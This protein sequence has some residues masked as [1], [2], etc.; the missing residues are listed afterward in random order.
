MSF[1][2]DFCHP[3][4]CSLPRNRARTAQPKPARLQQLELRVGRNFIRRAGCVS[5]APPPFTP[6]TLIRSNLSGCLVGAFA[7]YSAHAGGCRRLG[8]RK[9]CVWT[10]CGG[11]P[12]LGTLAERNV[13]MLA[14]H[15]EIGPGAELAEPGFLKAA[16]IV[17]LRGIVRNWESRG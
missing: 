14:A 15:S 8:R 5:D 1:R 9:M 2:L 11:H 12:V 17:F 13:T 6:L 7:G 4:V 3:T 10:D 16:V